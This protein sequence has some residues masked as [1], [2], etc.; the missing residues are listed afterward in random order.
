MDFKENNN[1]QIDK[2]NNLNEDALYALFF[3]CAH[4]LKRRVG[5]KASRHLILSILDQEGSVSQREIQSRLG[6]QAGSLSEILSRMEDRGLLVREPSEE[7]RRT[8]V[9]RITEKGRQENALPSGPSDEELF[10]MLS[11]QE[12]SEMKQSF[13]KIIEAHE[14]WKRS[15]SKGNK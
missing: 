4:I 15:I 13:R 1:Y 12:R 10:R 2:D 3:R 11:L 9:L 14:N 7:D 6:I 8:T 5:S